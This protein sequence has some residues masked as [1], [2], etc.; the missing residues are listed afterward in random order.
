MIEPVLAGERLL[1]CRPEP[2]ASALATTLTSVGAQ[3]ELLPTIAIIPLA[4][5]AAAR[6]QLRHLDQ[7]QQVIVVSQHAAELGLSVL[8]EFWPELPAEQKWYAI[9]RKTA[10]HLAPAI[11]ASMAKLIAPESDLVSEELLG[12]AEL[13]S[14]RGQK[15]LLLKGKGGRSTLQ[16]ELLARGA[17]GATVELYERICPTYSQRAL[18]EKLELFDPSYIVALSGETLTN[19]ILLSTQA[20][21]DLRQ[22]KL[23]LPSARVAQLAMEQGFKLTYVPDNLM[24]IDII[25]CVARARR[26]IGRT[27]SS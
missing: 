12:L 20:K 8:S 6:E 7:Y 14:I 22:R 10:E 5:G 11:A 4:L 3:C 13:Q 26:L 16:S 2:S 25:R 27:H 23:I 18:E 15:I 9:G 21:I 19:L 1:I 24:P 17:K